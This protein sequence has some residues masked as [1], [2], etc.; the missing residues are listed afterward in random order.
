MSA[1]ATLKIKAKKQMNID[2]VHDLDKVYLSYFYRERSFSFFFILY[3][4]KGRVLSMFFYLLENILV[5]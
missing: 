4:I 1:S 5:F 2:S 3:T